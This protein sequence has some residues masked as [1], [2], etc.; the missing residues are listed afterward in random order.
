MAH[1]TDVVA[2]AEREAGIEVGE[3]TARPV[4][5]PAREPIDRSGQPLLSVQYVTR[6]ID[7]QTIIDNVSFNVWPGEIFGIMGMSGSGKTTLLR[8]LIGLDRPDSGEI[9]FKG[10]SI[11]ELSEDELNRVRKSMGMCFQYSA[12]FDSMT[13]AENVGFAV[14]NRRD[15]SQ[16]QRRRR[17]AELLDMVEMEGTEDRMPADL[18]GGMRKR[19]SIARALMEEPE[20]VLYDEP[21]SGLDPIMACN[22]SGLIKKVSTDTGSTAIIV[23]HDVPNL[24]GICDRILMLHD[25]K[26]QMIGTPDELREDD[27][28]VVHRF[29]H[30][31][32][33]A[34]MTEHCSM[35]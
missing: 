35:R 20:L 1:D 2:E 32:G 11:T 34:D 31:L 10:E 8:L 18:S 13:V 33:T 21:S 17:V 12:L 23:S 29:V 30:G 14:R 27:T 7:G 3:E 28:P 19:V 9:L 15:L 4:P 16:D 5:L 22:I 26:V 6:Q 24:L 25:Q